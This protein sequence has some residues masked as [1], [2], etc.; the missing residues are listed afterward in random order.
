MSSNIQL[1]KLYDDDG[2]DDGNL[3]IVK[4]FFTTLPISIVTCF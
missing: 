3:N 1:G 2:D 4:T